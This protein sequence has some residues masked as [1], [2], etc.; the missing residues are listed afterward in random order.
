LIFPIIFIIINHI[1]VKNRDIQPKIGILVSFLINILLYESIIV[2]TDLSN[3]IFRITVGLPEWGATIINTLANFL[4]VFI[5][6]AGMKSIIAEIKIKILFNQFKID[7]NRPSSESMMNNLFILFKNSNNVKIDSIAEL[8]NM[9]RGE[10]IGFIVENYESLGE[11]KIKD[12][13]LIINSDEG[14]NKFI[15]S[16]DQLFESWGKKEKNKIGKV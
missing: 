8:M 10:F 12:D 14:V 7:I 3:N 16:L 15:R 4:L 2:Y 11:I 6:L 1:R 5:S 9:K 13:N